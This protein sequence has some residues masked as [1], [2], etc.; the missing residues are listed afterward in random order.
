MDKVKSGSHLGQRPAAHTDMMRLLTGRS[1]PPE[2]ALSLANQDL[3]KPLCFTTKYPILTRLGHENHVYWVIQLMRLG[4]QL[5]GA[6]CHHSAAMLLACLLTVIQLIKKKIRITGSS[7]RCSF[8][9]FSSA[10]L[11]KK[12]RRR[13]P[14][15][16]ASCA[17]VRAGIH[18]T[19]ADPPVTGWIQSRQPVIDRATATS[20]SHRA[21]I[22]AHE[23]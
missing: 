6:L 9:S 12:N 15:T 5:S 23:L 4:K 14:R 7:A 16:Q 19:V 1:P 2:H 21:G 3:S 11:N 22:S 18:E 8:T 17:C 20:C 10:L 13:H